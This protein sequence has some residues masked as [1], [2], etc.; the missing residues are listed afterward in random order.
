MIKMYILEQKHG[1]KLLHEESVVASVIQDFQKTSLSQLRR[2]KVDISDVRLF[3]GTIPFIRA[4][5]M[6][7]HLPFP[8]VHDYSDGIEPYLGRDIVELKLG[9]VR[10]M[11]QET[12]ESYFIKPS[13]S[14][15]KF[16]GIV[17]RDKC[18]P[19]LPV[20]DSHYVYVSSVIDFETEWRAYI[21]DGEVEYLSH[22]NG[23]PSIIPRVK[24]ISEVAS[25]LKERHGMRF[26][27]MDV[28]VV[29]GQTLVVEV[30]EG[31]SLGLYGQFRPERYLALLQGRWNQLT[32]REY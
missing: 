17:T 14:L 7:S 28:G 32:K 9:Q 5:L 6:Q 4:A 13:R 24:V 18:D 2:G 30:N 22:Y 10:S 3:V 1:H 19:R 27:G 26:Y 11:I 29:E 31:F 20:G 15:K 25:M 16:P 8:D 23:N 12:G 21:V